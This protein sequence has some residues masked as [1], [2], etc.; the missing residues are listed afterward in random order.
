MTGTDIITVVKK[1]PV[2]MICGT[3]ALLCGAVLYLR[4]DVIDETKAKV[5]ELSQKSEVMLSNVRNSAG[6]AQQTEAIR[7]SAK[8]VEGRLV[9]A[10][11]LATNLQHFYRLESETGLKLTDVRQNQ[12]GRAGTGGYIGIPYSVT[13]QG[14][15]KQVLE[16]FQRIE[17]GKYFSK[18]SSISVN[19]TAG[20]EPTGV[21]LLSVSMNIELL[22]TP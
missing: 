3:I 18:F 6:L 1:Y 2:G 7:R 5:D 12:I 14:T 22:G 19:K 21:S 8:Q 13:F 15:F 16:F 17:S 10:S 11:Q 20:A 9:K 4:S